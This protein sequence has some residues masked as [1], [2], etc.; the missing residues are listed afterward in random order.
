MAMITSASHAPWPLDVAIADLKSAGLSVPSIV[1]LK[2]FALACAG[3]ARR[4]LRPR[5]GPLRHNHR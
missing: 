4:R 5:K 3:F 1:R 2:L